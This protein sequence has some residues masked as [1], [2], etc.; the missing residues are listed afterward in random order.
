MCIILKQY[1]LL[2]YIQHSP[3]HGPTKK[4][5]EDLF[6]LQYVFG[7]IHILH[8]PCVL[9][10]YTECMNIEYSRVS[11]VPKSYYKHDSVVVRLRKNYTGPP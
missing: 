9:S 5:P 6:H 11:G 7:P 3:A 1:I 4:V 10:Y 2:L 8:F